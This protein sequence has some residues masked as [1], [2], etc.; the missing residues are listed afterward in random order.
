M[1]SGVARCVGRGASAA[2]RLIQLG[3]LYARRHT[4]LP[5]FDP[6]K[7]FFFSFDIKPI[8]GVTVFHKIENTLPS[9][10]LRTVRF[11]WM[12]LTVQP[13]ATRITRIHM[14]CFKILIIPNKIR[15][16]HRGQSRSRMPYGSRAENLIRFCLHLPVEN[17]TM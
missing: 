14:D 10:S 16:S 6:I 17:G 2:W 3:A 4:A 13:D 1:D 12:Y 15:C 11:A 9:H 5:N 8:K 7:S